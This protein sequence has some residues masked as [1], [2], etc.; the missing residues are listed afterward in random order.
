MKLP[1]PR[2]AP[3]WTIRSLLPGMQDKAGCC[4]YRT[5][6][7]ETKSRSV[8]GEEKEASGSARTSVAKCRRR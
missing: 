1:E 2:F 7:P 4:R 3:Y 8:R 6:G 5:R